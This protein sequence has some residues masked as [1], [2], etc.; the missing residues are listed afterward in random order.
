MATKRLFLL[1][2]LLL[3]LV[4]C[5]DKGEVTEADAAK[6]KEAFS[7]EAYE[8]AMR[9]AG[10]GAELDEQRRREAERESGG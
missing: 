5:G 2:A 3:L 8:D 10:K 7:K 9:K 4:G 6:N 1:P